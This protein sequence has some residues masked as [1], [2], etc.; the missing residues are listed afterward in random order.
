MSLLAQE[1]PVKLLL[2][3]IYLLGKYLL[4]LSLVDKTHCWAP[5][6]VAPW[7]ACSSAVVS[8]LPSDCTGSSQL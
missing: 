2:S 6:T 8:S 5:W 3:F 1:S 7:N 4:D